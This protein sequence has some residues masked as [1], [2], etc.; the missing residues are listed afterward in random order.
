MPAMAKWKSYY[1][2]AASLDS[3]EEDPA[4]LFA[5]SVRRV[6]NGFIDHDD[7]MLRV[8]QAA[9][10]PLPPGRLERQMAQ[11]IGIDANPIA[12][13]MHASA[14]SGV[15]ASRWNGFN[16]M[17]PLGVQT[18]VPDAP[19]AALRR[20]PRAMH[21]DDHLRKQ[22]A[23]TCVAGLSPDS[24]ARPPRKDAPRRLATQLDA[25]NIACTSLQ[26]SIDY[27]YEEPAAQLADCVQA[28]GCTSRTLQRELART[29]LG[30][31][32]LRQAVR[33]TMAGYAIR[34]RGGSLTEIAHTAGFFDSAHFV[35]AW[36][37]SCGITPSQYRDL[38]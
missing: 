34:A 2:L 19:G 8:T 7:Y 22:V 30:F 29:G 15:F 5:R 3:A 13:L 28:L 20:T 1:L 36:K 14:D 16:R 32:A 26:E 9:Q 25:L 37:D 18:L 35:R 33:L 4:R 11:L 24:R 21:A 12:D 10:Q 27:L 6:V 17:A 23:A 31:S 38:V